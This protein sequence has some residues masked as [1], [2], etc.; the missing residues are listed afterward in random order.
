MRNLFVVPA[1]VL[2][3]VCAAASAARAQVH[4][5]DGGTSSRERFTIPAVRVDHAPRIDGVLD[6]AEWAKAPVVETFVQQEPREGT[7]ATERTEVRVLYDS[8]QLLIA[9]HAYDLQPSALVATE[10]R[11]DADRLLDEDN[12]Q[13][14]LDTFNDS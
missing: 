12:F 7:P 2:V 8:R 1:A 4:Q 14:I 10:M 5:H 6:D 9:V 3:C 13:I 11:R